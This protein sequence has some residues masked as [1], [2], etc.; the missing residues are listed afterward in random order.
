M[1]KRTLIYIVEDDESIRELETYAL[2]NSDFDVNSFE[3]SKQ[4]FEKMGE[5]LPELIILDVMLPEDD[6]LKVLT[7]LKNNLSYSHIPVVLV[8]AKTSEIDAVKGLDMGADDYIKKPFGVMELI[9]RVKAVLRRSTTVNSPL[10][11]FENIIIDE[12]RHEV[13]V[14]GVAKELTYKE[15]EI[16]KILIRNK[17][18]VLTRDLLMENIWG[19]DFEQGNRTVDVHIQSL[20]KKIGSA[21]DHIKTIRNVGYKIGE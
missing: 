8:T 7:K 5:K 19:Y 17:G 9:S 16:L 11:Q 3:S 15:Y 14:D 13:L 2:K 6:G 18:I 21:G 1:K 4:L 20:R 10:L 12:G